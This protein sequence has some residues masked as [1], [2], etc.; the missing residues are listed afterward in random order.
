MA[1]MMATTAVNEPCTAVALGQSQ[2]VAAS[3]R[4]STVATAVRRSPIGW[5]QVAMGVVDRTW[6]DG[7]PCSHLA[8]CWSELEYPLRSHHQVT[9]SQCVIQWRW[10]CTWCRQ[11]GC[12]TTLWMQRVVP[13]GSCALIDSCV[14]VGDVVNVP[15]M[16]PT[17]EEEEEEEEEGVPSSAASSPA[18]PSLSSSSSSSSVTPSRWRVRLPVLPTALSAA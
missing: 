3:P 5:Q 13:V 14:S 12:T 2:D 11:R 18:P 7:R 9:V 17:R 15:Q 10:Y 6:A 16:N 8:V 1:N 4:T